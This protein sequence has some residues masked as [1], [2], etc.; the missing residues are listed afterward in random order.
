MFVSNAISAPGASPL[1]QEELQVVT[2]GMNWDHDHES[3]D[4]IDARGGT[5][6]MLGLVWTV[7]TSG[8]ISS[9]GG[10]A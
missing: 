8:H 9:L 4:V 5:V 10:P 7:D 1:A 3:S 6:T 2:G